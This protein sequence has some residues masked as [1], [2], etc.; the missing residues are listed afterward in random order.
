VD[1]Y[2]T[3]QAVENA[4]PAALLEARMKMDLNTLESQWDSFITHM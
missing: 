1:N 3:V 4:E 2:R